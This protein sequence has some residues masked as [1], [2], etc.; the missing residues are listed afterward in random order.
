MIMEPEWYDM[1]DK[2]RQGM[3]ISQIAREE[4]IDRKT[5]RK[6]LRSRTPP[7]YRRRK[8]PRSKLDQFKDYIKEQYGLHHLSAVKMLEVISEMGYTGGY[9][10]LKDFMST[11]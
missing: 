11:S 6:H 5:V 9:T 10:I 2:Q 7:K 8:E 1:K 3:S 4:G